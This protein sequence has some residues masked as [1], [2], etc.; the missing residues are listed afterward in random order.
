MEAGSPSV[1]MVS[2]LVVLFSV[3]MVSVAMSVVGSLEVQELVVEVVV[4]LKKTRG[5]WA[6]S[7][8]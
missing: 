6:T 2:W 4:L 8:T 3:A 5:P 1:A 7:L